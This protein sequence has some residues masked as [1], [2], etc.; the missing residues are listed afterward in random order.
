[1]I[2]IKNGYVVEPESGEEGIADILIDRSRIDRLKF[3]GAV[4]EF[5]PIIFEKKL[6]ENT[7]TID[8][9][10]LVV[11]P[12]LVDV[13]VHFREPGFE[14]KEDILTGSKAAAKGGFTSVVLMANTKPTVDNEEILSFVLEKGKKT[15]IHVHTCASVS[16]GQLGKE[17][18]DFDALMKA[19]AVG[20]TDDGMPLMDCDFLRK[21]MEETA[22]LQM[23]ISLHEEDPALISENGIHAGR[24][25]EH[26][27]L[28]GSP[29]EA[30]I[31]LVERDVRLA[32]ETGAVLNVQHV[33]CKETVEILRR[34]KV[35]PGGERIH[36]E[37]TP[38]HFTLTQVGS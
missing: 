23:P 12:G 31:R 5:S 19:G 32:L 3:K 9:H 8:A 2:L 20:F 34:A 21:A 6:D 25:S 1:M 11:A 13:H 17:Q 38:H 22:R 16:R 4:S 28:K 24:A 35:T 30:E 7:F 37:A 36:G 14:Y 27:G 15:G 26:F 18:V 33:S 10:G 29:R